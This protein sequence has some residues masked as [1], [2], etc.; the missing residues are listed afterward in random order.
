MVKVYEIESQTLKDLIA[1]KC[2]PNYVIVKFGEKIRVFSKHNIEGDEVARDCV[3][4]DSDMQLRD[5]V[6]ETVL[7][8]GAVI[9]AHLVPITMCMRDKIYPLLHVMP[10]VL[11]GD[12]CADMLKVASVDRP[13]VVDAGFMY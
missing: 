13:L 10:F 9:D 1:G 4:L 5:D 3:V 11:R 12:D 7:A 8:Q 2:P 6:A